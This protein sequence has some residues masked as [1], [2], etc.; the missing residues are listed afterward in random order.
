[1]RSPGSK[2]FLRDMLMDNN[3]CPASVFFSFGLKAVLS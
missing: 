3:L 1:M 2:G